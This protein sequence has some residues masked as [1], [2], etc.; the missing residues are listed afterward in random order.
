MESARVE[1]IRALAQLCESGA[2]TW[3]QQEQGWF[4]SPDEIVRALA[5]EGFEEFKHEVTRSGRGRRPSGGLWQ[6]LNIRTGAVGSAVWVQ[7]EEAG[8]ALVFVDVDGAP[9]HGR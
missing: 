9:V 2:M 1:S 5:S 8:R 4:A 3:D 7:R 6:G